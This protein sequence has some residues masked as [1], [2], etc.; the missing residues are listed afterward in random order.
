M[1]SEIYDDALSPGLEVMCQLV[2]NVHIEAKTDRVYLGIL[3][4]PEFE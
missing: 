1:R 4:L 3:L 2:E